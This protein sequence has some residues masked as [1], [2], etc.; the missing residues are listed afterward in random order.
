M[1]QLQAQ[2]ET[3][4]ALTITPDPIQR[5]D[6][7]IVGRA[8]LTRG[9]LERIEGMPGDIDRVVGP[10]EDMTIQLD[11]SAI[12]TGEGEKCVGLIPP[13][14][15]QAVLTLIGDRLTLNLLVVETNGVIIQQRSLLQGNPVR[16]GV[17]E[18][19]TLPVF[20]LQ[21]KMGGDGN[22]AISEGTVQIG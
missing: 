20:L 7:L 14:P 11:A 10:A 15:D 22:C 5:V 8:I 19:T 16:F 13:V 1:T 6:D 4:D 12:Q 18:E 17:P 3:D 2:G 21:A 9:M